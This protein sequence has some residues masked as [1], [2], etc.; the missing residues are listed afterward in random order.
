MKAEYEDVK[1]EYEEEKRLAVVMYGGVSLAVY[2]AGIARE[3]LGVVRATSPRPKDPDFAGVDD[4][5]LSAVEKLYREV[6][7]KDRVL[8]TRVTVDVISGT[9]AGGINGIFLAKA[10]ANSQAMDSVLKLWVEEGDLAKLLNDAESV[11]ST[12]L[13]PDDPPAALLNG[14]RMYAKLVEAFDEMDRAP[15][16]PPFDASRVDLFVTTTD[17]PGEVIQLPVANAVARETRHRQRFHFTAREPGNNELGQT[18]NP[19]LAFAARCTSSFPAAFEPF[20][21]SDALAIE[22]P[23]ANAADWKDRL[24]FTGADYA[25]RPFGDGG[26]LDNKPFSYAIDELSRRQSHLRV[27]RTLLY[28]EPDPEKLSTAEHA[29]LQSSKPDAIENALA[30]MTLPSYETIREDLER[31]V[32]RNGRIREL[33]SLERTIEATL[34]KQPRPAPLSGDE[35][36]SVTLETLVGRYGVAYPAYHEL[37]VSSVVESIADEMC[38]AGKI[39]RPELMQVVREL[40]TWWIIGAYPQFPDELRLLL[41]ADLEYRLR[42][43][44]FVLRRA[45]AGAKPKVVQARAALKAACDEVYR[46]RQT[47]RERLGATLGGLR[48]GPLADQNLEAIATLGRRDR[49]EEIG[50]LLIKLGNTGAESALTDCI[51]EQGLKVKAIAESV[52]AALP[53]G[54]PELMAL[55]ELHDLFESFDMIIYPI[56]RRGEV[57][58]AVDVKIVRV[59]PDDILEKRARPLAGASL[60]HFGAFLEEQWRHHDILCG[61]LDGAETIIRLLE[62]DEARASAKVK[63]AHEELVQEMLRPQLEARLVTLDAALKD[64]VME[65]IRDKSKLCELFKAGK[66]Y[67]LGLDR[68]QQVRSAGRAGIILEKILRGW[69]LKAKFP[70]PAVLRWGVLLLAMMG[71]VAI[72][73]TLQRTVTAHWVRLL[74]LGCVLITAGGAITNHTAVMLTGVKGL[75]VIATLGLATALIAAWIG[76]KAARLL[77]HLLSWGVGLALVGFGVWALRTEHS[78]V[79]TLFPAKVWLT[80]FDKFY[81][82]LGAGLLIGAWFQNIWSDLKWLVS[83]SAHKLAARMEGTLK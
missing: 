42:K 60:G 59:G 35:W 30:A 79:A 18:E 3:L 43:F 1:A 48:K 73:R 37:K 56:V 11:R 5:H 41:D 38:A 21:W 49:A 20:T 81:A 29:K 75:A 47:F 16:A 65:V 10:L 72:P 61:R 50:D 68:A 6:A 44:T 36:K 31:V 22:A 17:L 27:E 66:G 80:P 23:R 78:V 77:L 19:L 82:G 62:K 34:R 26:Y 39:G 74:A 24:L 33:L 46:V 63:E 8:K 9:S 58:E 51:K 52:V 13:A 14:R 32:Q 45:E 53:Q 83:W 40:V 15:P 2:I 76:D 54:V 25:H 69:A 4:A 7:S 64:E 12:A 28:V 70:F 71:Q 67:S 55:R 57:D